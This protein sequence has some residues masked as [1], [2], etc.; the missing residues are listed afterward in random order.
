[1]PSAARF[2]TFTR[3]TPPASPL[4]R[5]RLAAGAA[6]LAILVS[7]CTSTNDGSDA[8]NATP[9]APAPTA[10]SVDA[11]SDTEPAPVEQRAADTSDT[12]D[13]ATT[14]AGTEPPAAPDAVAVPAALQFSAPLVGGGEF[15]GAAYADKP[16]VF[17]FWAPT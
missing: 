8:E 12:A 16:T 5:R 13:D 17:W 1:M 7:A 15:D 9:T 6:A 10:E 11:P 3:V 14:D 4:V 2:A